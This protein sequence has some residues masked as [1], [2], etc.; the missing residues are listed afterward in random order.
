MINNA[1]VSGARCVY[2]I[3]SGDVTYKFVLLYNGGILIDGQHPQSIIYKQG[4]SSF[5]FLS[6]NF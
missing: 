4:V 2:N 6:E 3:Q 5:F 1:S